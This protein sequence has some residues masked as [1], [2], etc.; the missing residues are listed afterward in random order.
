MSADTLVFMDEGWLL[1]N[2]MVDRVLNQRDTN[3]M[4]KIDAVVVWRIKR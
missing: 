2:N 4:G 3:S 1:V